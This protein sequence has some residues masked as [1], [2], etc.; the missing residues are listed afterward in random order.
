MGS[1]FH[2]AVPGAT[3]GF[4]QRF[5]VFDADCVARLALLNASA[6]ALRGLGY[7]VLVEDI[8]PLDGGRPSI[9]IGPRRARTVGAIRELSNGMSIQ[10][11]GEQQF[12]S[13]DFM[14]VRVTWEVRA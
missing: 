5:R 1:V 11:R 8:T 3:S 4:S 14:G 13:V 2:I 10:R 7:R 6:R 9:Q 12:A